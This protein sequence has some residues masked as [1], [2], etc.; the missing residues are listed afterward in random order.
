MRIRV[1]LTVAAIGLMP[2]SVQAQGCLGFGSFANGMVGI[3]ANVYGA[4]GVT[5]RGASINLGKPSGVFGGARL[6]FQEVNIANS[7]SSADLLLSSMRMGANVGYEIALGKSQRLSMCPMVSAGHR[8]GPNY[9]VGNAV[10]RETGNDYAG[11]VAIGGAIKLGAKADLVPSV[12][13]GYSGWIDEYTIVGGES[14]SRNDSTLDATFSAGVV[15]ANRFAI[16]PFV[17]ISAQEN[18]DPSIGLSFRVQLGQK[19]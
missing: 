14:A 5:G 11:A 10:I 9:A 12:S 8:F 4:P 1:A 7:N 3:G 16:L 15:I 18:S 19:R 13:I 17:A 6:G 2:D